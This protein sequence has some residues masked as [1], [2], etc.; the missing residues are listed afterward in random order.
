MILSC[1]GMGW[2]LSLAALKLY[3]IVDKVYTNMVKPI[4]IVSEDPYIY[5]TTVAG[6]LLYIFNHAQ[7]LIVS[8]HNQRPGPVQARHVIERPLSIISRLNKRTKKRNYKSNIT[9]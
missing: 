4:S 1:N 5:D 3:C 7:S 2:S 6:V 9:I 8:T